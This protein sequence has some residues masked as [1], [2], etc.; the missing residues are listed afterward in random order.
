[1]SKMSDAEIQA[2]LSQFPDWSELGGGIQRTFQFPDFLAAMRFV[3]GVAQAA[4]QRQHHP[5]ILIRYNKVTMTL[6]THDA[7]GITNKDFDLA[8]EIDRV[9]LETGPAPQA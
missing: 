9:A 7:G 5:D 8:R 1:M 6:S 2:C 3:N 4:E